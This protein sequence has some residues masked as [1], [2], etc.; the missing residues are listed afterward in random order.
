VRSRKAF[1][2]GRLLG[3]L[4]ASSSLRLYALRNAPDFDNCTGELLALYRTAFGALF[5]DE[6]SLGATK[7]AVQALAHESGAGAVAFRGSVS[8]FLMREIHP[9]CAEPAQTVVLECV[10]AL[11]K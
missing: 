4:M 3:Y 10:R 8:L 5:G 6:A 9:S 2:Y 11:E 7:A 1:N